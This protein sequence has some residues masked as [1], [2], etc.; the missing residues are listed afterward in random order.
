MLAGLTGK[1]IA[2]QAG[3]VSWSRTQAVPADCLCLRKANG[4]WPLAAQRSARKLGGLLQGQRFDLDAQIHI[5][6]ETPVLACIEP[7]G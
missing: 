3:S 4:L 6:L 1:H 7:E 2:R 5:H